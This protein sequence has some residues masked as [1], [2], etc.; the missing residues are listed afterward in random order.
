MVSDVDVC[1][2]VYQISLLFLQYTTGII[3]G[4]QSLIPSNHPLLVCDR[5]LENA[6]SLDDDAGDT[7]GV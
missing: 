3:Q 6:G 1:V 2:G 4:I 7:V 5:R